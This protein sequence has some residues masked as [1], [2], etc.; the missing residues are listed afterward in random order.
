M[1]PETGL[2]WSPWFRIIAENFLPYWWKNLNETL[3]T[4]KYVDVKTIHRFDPTTEH[5]G[6]AGDA[7]SWLGQSISPYSKLQ[8]IPTSPTKGNTQLK[9]GA[10][11]KVRIHKH[12]KISQLLHLD[13]I[14]AALQLKFGNELQNQLKISNSQLAFCDDMLGKVSRS[15][16]A[17]IRQLPEGL[18]VDIM[19]FYLVLRA[20]DTVEDDMKAFEGRTQEKIYLLKNF[21]RIALIDPNWSLKGV[22]EGDE[23]VLIEQ[24]H[25]V[26]VTFQS[27]TSASQIVISDIT[28]R[29]GEGMAQYV[30]KDL[31]QGTILVSDYDLYCHYVAGLVGEGLSR[32]FECTGYES[33]A[34]GS[35]STTLA[36]T[37]GLFLQKTNIIRDYLE[38]YVDGRTFWPKEIWRKYTRDDNL[39]EFTLPENR[40]SAVN[41]LN[42]LVT[43][44]LECIPEC[45]SYLD[46]LN[47]KEVFRF[48]AI[49]Q[50]MAIGTLS[51]LYNNPEVFT[52]VVKIRKG[53]AAKLIL[54]SKDLN[55]VHKW[56]ELFAKSIK[57]RIPDND[58]NAKAT[59][60]ICNK[61]IELTTQRS[62]LSRQLDLLDRSVT[63]VC[64]VPFIFILRKFQNPPLVNALAILLGYPVMMFVTRVFGSNRLLRWL[65]G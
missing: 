55:G 65:K 13:E 16:A 36:N 52:G 5:M 4:N 64:L 30:E 11:G 48:C 6:G 10:Y 8:S 49:P 23:A 45:L 53:M 46:L 39:G 62:Q 20:L 42:H 27:L 9:Q 59:H 14:F 3:T 44:A 31:G 7:G 28:R 63:T 56:F 61:V 35:V 26:S 33:S 2:L 38:D 1:K 54:D 41:C 12:S 37:M 60:D 22:G 29:M 43:N 24:F 32:L 47:N 25:N 21:Y 18:I 40:Q 58:P 50:V 57:K 51:E 15:F 17:V 19:I 34:V